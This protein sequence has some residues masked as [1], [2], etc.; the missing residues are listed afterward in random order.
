MHKTKTFDEKNKKQNE[1]KYVRKKTY[2]CRNILDLDK[3]T[4]EMNVNINKIPTFTKK[5]FLFN[6][7]KNLRTFN[8]TIKLKNKNKNSFNISLLKHCN[9]ITTNT[10]SGEKAV[11]KVTFSTVEIIRVE[12]YK[13]YNALSNFSKSQIQKNMEDLKQNDNES[14]CLIF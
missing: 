4:S 12:K 11:K 6:S 1:R 3:D 10:S 13:K 5:N 7:S 8:N 2:D 9:S 14:A